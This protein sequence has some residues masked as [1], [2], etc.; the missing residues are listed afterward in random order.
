MRCQL[1]EGP[2][3]RYKKKPKNTEPNGHT[4]A[5]RIQPS[6][7]QSSVHRE[8]GFAYEILQ[9]TAPHQIALYNFDT[10]ILF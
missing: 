9:C 4:T 8:S 10:T 1:F 2:V 5:G 3:K 6:L 7:L